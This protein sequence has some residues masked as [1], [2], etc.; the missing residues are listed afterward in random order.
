MLRSQRRRRLPFGVQANS[1]SEAPSS[2]AG[3]ARKGGQLVVSGSN[4]TSMRILEA[5]SQLFAAQGYAAT[6]VEQVVAAC[7]MGKDTVYRRFASKLALFEGVVDHARR[8]VEAHFEA[9]VMTQKGDVLERLRSCAR[10]LLTVNLDPTLVA[11][12]RIAFS[13]ALVVGQAV[14]DRPQ[15]MMEHLVRLVSEAQAARVI[16]GGDTLFIAMHLLNCI[17]IGPTVEAM[18]GRTAYASAR[19]QNIHFER[20]W[21]LFLNGVRP[22]D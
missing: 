20:S 18:L 5:A 15:L 1:Q 22:R 16:V 13:E 11:F 12:K 8:K 14:A 17:A 7:G 2:T 6:S 10:W 3:P 9:T 4:E 21:E 19:A